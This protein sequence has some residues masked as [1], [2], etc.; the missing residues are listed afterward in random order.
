MITEFVYVRHGETDANRAGILQGGGINLP[1][2]ENG[3]KQ[4]A[5]A[6]KYLQQ[7]FFDVAFASDLNRA[8]ETARIILEANQNTIPLQLVPQLR[9]WNCGEMDGLAFPEIYKRFPKEGKS[10]AFEQIETQ[11][12]GGEAG[13]DFQARINDFLCKLVKEYA[14]K[15]ILLVAHGGVQQRIFRLISGAPGEGNLLPLAGNAS[16]SS[17][18]YNHKYEAWQLTSWNIREHLKEL[19]QHSLRVL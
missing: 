10:F 6:A 8:A 1:L 2:N 3:R 14:G 11:M 4:A 17:F 16:V 19:P 18:I 7:E 12:P 15:K 5:A 9:E 13:L